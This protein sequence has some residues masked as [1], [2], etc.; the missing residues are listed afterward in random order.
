MSRVTLEARVVTVVQDMRLRAGDQILVVGDVCIGRHETGGTP[1]PA[2]GREAASWTDDEIVR[3]VTGRSLSTR[4]IGDVLGLASDELQARNRL[5]YQIHRLV[6]E[7]LMV[8]VGGGRIGVWSAR[9]DQSA[10]PLQSAS[11]R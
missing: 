1:T 3:V 8:K 7:G 9:A 5:S 2:P 4:R 10:L 11:A 6:A